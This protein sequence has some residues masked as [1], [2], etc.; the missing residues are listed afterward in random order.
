MW[1]TYYEWHTIFMIYFTFY[2]LV[3]SEYKAVTT[4]KTH[5]DKNVRNPSKQS[6]DGYDEGFVMFNGSPISQ[7]FVTTMGMAPCVVLVWISVRWYMNQYI[8]ILWDESLCNPS[9]PEVWCEGLCIMRV[10]I[11]HEIWCIDGW[12]WYPV[13]WQNIRLICM[14]FF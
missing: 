7:G 1:D 2:L 13:D 12:K 6:G 10:F 3:L 8:Y 11:V 5:R 14:D 9:G 4:K